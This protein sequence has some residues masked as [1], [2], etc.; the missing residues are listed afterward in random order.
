MTNFQFYLEKLYAS[1]EFEKF[2][3]EF[4]KAIPVSGFFVIDLGGTDLKQH[5]DYFDPES[6]K[7]WSFQLEHECAKV[8]LDSFKEYDPEKLS[9]NYNFDFDDVVKLI[10]AEMKTKEIKNKIQK[11][12]IS[13]QAKDK[14]DFLICT[15]FLSGMGML[16]ININIGEMKIIS[17][18]K[19]SFLD[20]I[21]VFQ[22][23]S[24][25]TSKDSKEKS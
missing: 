6:K 17:F 1:E 19:K 25:E 15:V 3:K 24:C 5:I 23:K 9:V 18:E 16:K 12:L 21:N 14:K 4:P 7:A 13:L 8:Q 2:K 11:I 22:K 10:Q 20:M